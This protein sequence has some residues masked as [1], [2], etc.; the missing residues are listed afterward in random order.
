MA[1]RGL[2]PQ[3]HQLSFCWLPPSTQPS[4]TLSSTGHTVC[5]NVCV[6]YLVITAGQQSITG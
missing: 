2:G 1:L 6:N 4:C 3:P 5:V